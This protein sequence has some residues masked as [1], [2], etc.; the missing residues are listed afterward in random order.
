M[1]ELIY[2]P[3]TPEILLPEGLRAR[4]ALRDLY[5]RDRERWRRVRDEYVEYIYERQCAITV[6]QA[7][8]AVAGSNT[9]TISVTY[10]STGA[11]ALLAC[12]IPHAIGTVTVTG[13]ADSSTATWT[14]A[15]Q[16]TDGT[17]GCEI[18]YRENAGSGVTSVTATFSGNTSSN[19][20][21]VAAYEFAGV[22]TASALGQVKTN[23]GS[24]TAT[25]IN[26][27]VASFTPD[28]TT[29]IILAGGRI[30]ATPSSW[31]AGTDYT[32]GGNTVRGGSE[33][34]IRTGAGAETAPL[35]AVFG[36]SGTRSWAEAVAEF[37]PPAATDVYG[38]WPQN[39]D[40]RVVREIIG[41]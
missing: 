28:S 4:R 8:A 40:P 39:V 33:Y 25:T 17:Q 7:P 12:V 1:A 9:T 16:A 3:P 15:C 30:S 21:V 41:Y 5:R 29:S 32:L 10:S 18:W 22:A 37:K 26:L 13:V 20:G 34:K 11:G 38:W 35:D 36:A 2:R 24:Q 23:T 14:Q 19:N 27:S 31:A 6:T